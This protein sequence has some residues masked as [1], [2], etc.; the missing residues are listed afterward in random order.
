MDD[1]HEP[2][3]SLPI[4]LTPICAVGAS[5]GGIVALQHLFRDLPDN[6]GLAYVVVIHLSPDHPSALPEILATCTNMPVQQVVDTLRIEPDHVYIIAPDRELVIDGDDVAAR[7]FVEPRG[8]RA[9]IDLL[10]RSVARGRGDGIAV[11]LSGGGSDGAQGVRTSKEAGGTILVQEPSEADFPSMPLAAIT[12]GSAD[13]IA[14]VARLAGHIAEVAR[15]KATVAIPSE[16]A[17]GDLRRILLLLRQRTGHDFTNYKRATVLRRIAR[18][19]QMHRILQIEDYASFLQQTPEET[20]KLLADLLISVTMFFRDPSAFEALRRR[21]I[22]PLL[23]AIGDSGEVRAWVVGCATGEEAYSLA[24]LL[25]E[26]ADRLQVH[27]PIQ[28]FASDVDERALA[29][30]REGRYPH[31]IEAQVSPER[32]RRFFVNEGTHYRV[33]PEIRDIVLFSLHSVV[34]EPPFVRLDL[35]VC[36]NVMIYMERALQQ[37]VCATFHY[38]LRSNRYLFL[39]SAEAAD[40]TQGFFVALDREARLYLSQPQAASVAFPLSAAFAP[41]RSPAP[42]PRPIAERIDAAELLGAMHAAALEARAP[43]SA[44]VDA[45]HTILHLSP[46]AGRF[47]AMPGGPSTNKLLHIVR[48][49]LS[50]DLQV[51]LERAFDHGE[52]TLTRSIGVQFDTVRRGV[53]LHVAPVPP[54]AGGAPRAIVS[55]LEHDRWET[56]EDDASA[57]APPGELQRVLDQ[58]REAQHRGEAMR[59]EYEAVVQDLRAANE[60]LQSLNEEYRSTAEELETSKEELHSINEELQTVNA[61]LKDK[62]SVISASHNDLQNLT[63]SSEIGTLF[64]DT[65]L[66]IRMFTPPVATLFNVAQGDVGRVITDFTHHLAYDGLE[67]D[68]R[69]VLRDL[70]PIEEE[71]SSRDGRWLMVRVRLYRTLDDRVEGVVITFDDISLR[72]RTELA[73]RESEARLRAFIMASAD[74]VYRT[75]ADWSQ[76]LFVNDNAFVSSTDQPMSRWLDAYVAG[77]DR[78]LVL[79][80]IRGAV[81]T[82]E[83]FELEHRIQ[84]PDGG[85]GGTL[86]RAVPIRDPAGKVIEWIGTMRI[87]MERSKDKDALPWIK[88]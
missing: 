75:N 4:V 14:P 45:E 11:I 68:V 5:A 10:L 79:E 19:M 65:N 36:R 33:G 16:D 77:P 57:D 51:A 47:I 86:S 31:T 35:V 46:R 24:I 71:V 39:G 62:L 2:S 49:E 58:L 6:L 17:A 7:P 85:L 87:V 66:R 81:E 9:P 67:R 72:K 13:F 50:L 23:E 30:A 28:V 43:P 61:E 55:F 25:L 8:Q 76:L 26:E 40:T 1:H 18:R 83:M 69:C 56:S 74:V 32:L 82:G 44:L 22:R 15:G 20:N 12:T 34:R 70:K 78:I 27:V 63:A 3:S 88:I 73:L 80:A 41:Y 38:A 42:A 29:T 84:L 52:S 21:A 60:E 54:A 53:V 48:H 64:L 59:R 37:Q